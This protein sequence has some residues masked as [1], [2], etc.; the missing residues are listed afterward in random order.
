MGVNAKDFAKDK[1]AEI[2]QL[3]NDLRYINNERL[4][5]QAVVRI[6]TLASGIEEHLEYLEVKENK[7]E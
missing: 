7:E 3:C 6:E 4:R 2:L 1:L 5:M